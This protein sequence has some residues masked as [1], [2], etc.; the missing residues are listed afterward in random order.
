MKHGRLGEETSSMNGKRVRYLVLGNGMAGISAAAAIRAQDQQGHITMISAEDTWTYSRPMLTKTP[1]NSYDVKR[2]YIQPEDWYTDQGIGLVLATEIQKLDTEAKKVFT[3]KGIFDYDTCIIALGA[4]NAYP[5]VISPDCKCTV[6]IRTYQDIQKL[7]RLYLGAKNAVI[8]GGGVIGLEMAVELMKLSIQVTI[9]EAFP[10][11]LPRFLDEE[12]SREVENRLYPAQVLTGAVISR[13]DADDTQVNVLLS[14]GTS[15]RADFAVIS[16]GVR[17]NISVAKEAGIA[18]ERGIIVNEWMETS[19]PGVYACG[20]CAQFNGNN[21]ALWVQSKAQ[22]QVAGANAAGKK[23]RY[24]A[25]D[26]SLLF[27]C[28]KFA[29][30]A[31]GDTGK[32]P[33]VPYTIETEENLAD[34][35][36]AVNRFATKGF[37][38]TLYRNGKMTGVIQIGSLAGT[39]EVRKQ[40]FPEKEIYEDV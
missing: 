19:A 37:R 11:L 34:G 26:H 5:P 31:A 29:L 30:F 6:S 16:T 12:T 1:L 3:T 10:Y 15:V 4:S 22:G 40:L 36:F 33:D 7:K 24:G 13:F 20:D 25:I 8:I 39:Q 14:D 32:N 35:L 28:P 38:K 9:I 2:T 17:A 18:C 27:H 23:L 21:Y